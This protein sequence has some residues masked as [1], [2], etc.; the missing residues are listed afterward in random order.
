MQQ[1]RQIIK[2]AQKALNALAKISELVSDYNHEYP[3]DN[4]GGSEWFCNHFPFMADLDEFNAEISTWIRTMSE[5]I[6]QTFLVKERYDCN[7]SWRSVAEFTSHCDASNFAS[8]HYDTKTNENPS[9]P[10]R[11]KECRDGWKAAE[12][13]SYEVGTFEIEDSL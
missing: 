11:C 5:N 8:R 1:K 12:W 13:Q 4:L 7:D 9:Y 3:F 2:E 6:G 10:C